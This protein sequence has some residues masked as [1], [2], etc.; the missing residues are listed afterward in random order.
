MRENT[1]K[2]RKG[3]TMKS[4]EMRELETLMDEAL[5][6]AYLNSN[7]EKNKEYFKNEYRRLKALYDEAVENWL[8]VI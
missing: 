5:A 2:T 1:Y 4:D 7:R 3:N 8:A 6:N